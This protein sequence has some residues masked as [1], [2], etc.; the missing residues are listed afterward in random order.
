[1]IDATGPHP[2][3]V[4]LAAFGPGAEGFA[5]APNGQWAVTP[6]LL[7]S[8]L[9]FSD[10]AYTKNGE[11]VLMSIGPGGELRAASRQALGG[12]P[13]GVAFSGDS[14]YVY[15]GNYNDQDLQVFRIREGKLEP[16]GARMKLPGQPASMRGVAR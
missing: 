3:V 15:I 16:V 13:E 6:L 5:I 8:S 12:L 1:M 7:G 2:H 10:P 14:Q 11:A 4:N 9:K